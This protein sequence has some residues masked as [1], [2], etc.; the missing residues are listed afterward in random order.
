LAAGFLA[1][2]FLAVAFLAVAFGRPAAVL[3][4]EVFLAGEDLPAAVLRLAGDAAGLATDIVLADTVSALAAVLMALVAVLIAC[5]AVDRVLADAVALVAADVS[6]V[7]AVVT[8]TA[9]DE[10][11][12]AADAVFGTV[13]VAARAGVPADFLGPALVLALLLALLLLL[14]LLLVTAFGRLAPLLDGLPRWARPGAA[15]AEPRRPA[16]RV[17]LCTGIDLPPLVDQLRRAIPR[18]HCAHTRTG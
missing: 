3:A 7:A 11:V 16:V 14:V 6:R 10:T 8:F 1:A 5:M 15:F 13:L 12:L 9:A 18:L 2:G 4:V 17:P